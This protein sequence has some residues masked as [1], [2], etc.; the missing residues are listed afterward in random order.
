MTAP[1]AY[2]AHSDDTKA[3]TVASSAVRAALAEAAAVARP[4]EAAIAAASTAAST[5][6]FNLLGGAAAATE[7]EE[8]AMAPVQLQPDGDA[9][10]LEPKWLGNVSWVNRPGEAWIF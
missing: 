2:S 7:A 3:M 8:L 9:E 5:I 4:C 6:S 10:R 1:K